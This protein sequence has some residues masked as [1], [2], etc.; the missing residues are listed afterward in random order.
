[1]KFTRKRS[2]VIM[3]FWSG[4]QMV[5]SSE[6]PHER[7]M[8]YSKHFLR[9]GVVALLGMFFVAG[10]ATLS[11]VE[12]RRQERMGA[13][14]NL[15]EKQR[16]M[17]DAGQIAVGMNPDAVFI[18]WGQPDQVLEAEDSTG[19]TT[20]WLYHGTTTDEYLGWRLYE[21]PGPQGSYLARRL[22]RDVSIRE[23]ISA[24]LVFAEGQ[25]LRWKTLPRPGGTTNFG[26]HVY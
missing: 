17:V 2:L 22:E 26:G 3:V 21:V 25:L 23:Y 24:E 5:R 8:N 11:T 19:R 10:C 16:L 13:Y 15:D 7:S 4:A 12:E 20:T 18:A 1:M 6:L 14:L 9:L